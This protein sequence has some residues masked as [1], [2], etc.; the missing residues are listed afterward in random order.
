M[1]PID[2]TSKSVEATTWPLAQTEHSVGSAC[3]ASAHG[4]CHVA[5]QHR[6]LQLE[7]HKHLRYEENSKETQSTGR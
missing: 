6:S 2:N 5:P 1:R 3:T 7:P 4:I